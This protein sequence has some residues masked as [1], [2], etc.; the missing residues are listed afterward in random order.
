[1]ALMSDEQMCGVVCRLKL[2][3]CPL[4]QASAANQVSCIRAET[5]T[6]QDTREQRLLVFCNMTQGLLV[7]RP[8]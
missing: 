2:L 5:D 7:T 4:V 6:L 1:V 8:V 3:A